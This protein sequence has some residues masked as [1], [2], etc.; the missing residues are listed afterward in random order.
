MQ[1]GTRSLQADYDKDSDTLY[2][3]S[4]KDR[5]RNSV[6][7][8]N[9]ILDYAKDGSVIGV[10]FLNATETIPPIL[11]ASPKTLCESKFKLKPEALAGV[12]KA[13]VSAHTAADF[14]VIT[15]AL[16]LEGSVIQGKLGVP[17]PTRGLAKTLACA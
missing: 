12:L 11:F 3:Y 2:L 10:E 4:G 9:V 8:G 13:S 16:K 5:A 1:I 14:M 17:L 7:F 6:S 15:F